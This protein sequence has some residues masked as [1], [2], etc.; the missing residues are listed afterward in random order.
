LIIIKRT[1]V[2]REPR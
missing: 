1:G 2:R